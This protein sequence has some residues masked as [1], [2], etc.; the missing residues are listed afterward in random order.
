MTVTDG[1]L[2]K[3]DACAPEVSADQQAEAQC[4]QD[5]AATNRNVNRH[6]QHAKSD[7]T[8]KFNVHKEYGHTVN[9]AWKDLI[10]D[11]QAELDATTRD[12]IV[13]NCSRDFHTVHPYP[14]YPDHIVTFSYFKSE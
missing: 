7:T 6:D 9:K 2:G 5:G 11:R 10:A 12:L 8:D 13:G 3:K 4:E 1:A 14:K